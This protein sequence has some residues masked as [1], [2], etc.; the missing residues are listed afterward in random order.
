M[1]AEERFATAVG[2]TRLMKVE[3]LPAASYLILRGM[4]LWKTALLTRGCV[5]S[6]LEE[7]FARQRCSGAI[8]YLD[9][10]MCLLFLASHRTPQI[11]LPTAQ[12]V[13]ADEHHIVSAMR[14]IAND[15][16]Q[17][18]GQ[19]LWGLLRGPLNFTAIRAGADVV[20]VLRGQQ[21]TFRQ[22]TRLT[23]V[24]V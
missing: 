11:L 7:D 22:T 20:A 6:T 14:M 16:V 9:E 12:T 10:M 8:R 18:A 3:Q 2:K 23:L 1:A 15:K 21:V 19:Q 13:S 24:E 4:R 5:Y 17:L